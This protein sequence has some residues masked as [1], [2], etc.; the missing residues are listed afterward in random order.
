MRYTKLAAISVVP[1][2]IRKCRVPIKKRHDTSSI[3]LYNG[4]S[5]F[6]RTKAMLVAKFTK[7]QSVFYSY[8]GSQ[9]YKITESFLSFSTYK[10]SKNC[11]I[12]C[13]NCKKFFTPQMKRHL[14]Y[15]SLQTPPYTSLNH[16]YVSLQDRR[17]TK[18]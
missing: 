13:F 12:D 17:N 2:N 9:I 15:L 16:M 3:F 11:N 5:I 7:Y 1:C 14:A 8:A 4:N 10:Y 6:I 18:I